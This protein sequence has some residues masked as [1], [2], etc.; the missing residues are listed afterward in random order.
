MAY[1]NV[2][3]PRFYINTLEWLASNGVITLPSDHFRTLPVNPT[4]MAAKDCPELSNRTG[5]KLAFED[6]FNPEM[7]LPT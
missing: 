3:T 6:G 1:Q 2:G 7:M 4:F 5:L